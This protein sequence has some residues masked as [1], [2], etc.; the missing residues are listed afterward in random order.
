MFRRSNLSVLCF[1]LGVFGC[2]S[3]IPAA[4]Q[5]TL[6]ND[7]QW[8]G[9]TT[10]TLAFN[11][12]Q[13]PVGIAFTDTGNIMVSCLDGSVF[14]MPDVDG[15]NVAGLTPIYNLGAPGSGMTRYDDV[16]G[17]H[18]YAIAGTVWQGTIYELFPTSN[19]ITS[20]RV[21]SST[22]GGPQAL[23][24]SPFTQGHLIT[25]TNNLYDVD[26][27][28][29][30]GNVTLLANVGASEGLATDGTTL[31]HMTT[32]NYWV[33]AYTETLG[34]TV[35]YG[36]PPY[37]YDPWGWGV[38]GYGLQL[39]A[40]LL[41][42]HIFIGSRFGSLWMVD[43]STSTPTGSLVA[44]QTNRPD[45][46]PMLLAVDPNGSLLLP[47][48]GVIVRLTPPANSQKTF[49][50]VAAGSGHIADVNQGLTTTGTVGLS[51]PAPATVKV[52]LSTSTPG[53]T[54]DSSALVPAGHI[55]SSP[56]NVTTS[57]TTPVQATVTA[58]LNGYSTNITFNVHPLVPVSGSIATVN[59]G[60][61]TTGTVTLSGQ[62]PAG[63]VY[64][65]LSTTNAG[66]TLDSNGDQQVQVLVP[67][68]SNTSQPFPVNTTVASPASCTVTA[69]F[70][71]TSIP[72]NFTVNPLTL[73]GSI[74]TANASYAATCSLTLSFAP[75]NPAS[76]SLSTTTTGVVVPAAPITITAP[77]NTATCLIGTDVTTPAAATV[78][79][80]LNGVLYPINFTVNQ[81]TLT[82]SIPT[83][84]AGG[85]PVTGTLTLSFTPRHAVTVTLSGTTGIT[86]ASPLTVT[87]STKTFSVQADITTPASPQ[88]T[89]TATLNGVNYPIPF[90]VNQPALTISG[91]GTA[92]IGGVVRPSVTV[93]SSVKPS[94]DQPVTLTVSPSGLVGFPSGITIPK[95]Q[96]KSSPFTMNTNFV[97]TMTPVTVTASL[98]NVPSVVSNP[99]TIN[100]QPTTATL[101]IPTTTVIGGQTI[102]NCKATL[103]VAANGYTD[104]VF[105]NLVANPAAAISA[106][107]SAAALPIADGTKSS[108]FS[109]V[110]APVSTVTST[111]ITATPSENGYAGVG[112]TAVIK[113]KPIGISRASASGSNG[114]VTVTFFL[115]AP[116]APGDIIVGASDSLGKITF[117][118]FTVKKGW[119]YGAIIGTYT[120]SVLT[121]KI[122]VGVLTSGADT[123]PPIPWKLSN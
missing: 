66:V 42:N 29:S 70:N 9:W 91:L 117:T 113:I 39:G 81:L 95:L 48:Q 27:T 87:G 115:E 97:S 85:S 60:Y 36:F 41:A 78:T 1:L 63:G 71:N 38:N 53:V 3:S 96:S 8:S 89:V 67:A 82:G 92:M 73:T 17:P 99:V 24:P 112:G 118:P 56:F 26:P 23:V 62:A 46:E 49:L 101:T 79:A 7:P 20:P 111:T 109:I 10:S 80:T 84:S 94:V 98:T 105:A 15:Q 43:N 14:V 4:A 35:V 122:T 64:V 57:L 120:K 75:K 107:Q 55:T 103:N 68:G 40:G 69:T 34:D 28:L 21:V 31:Y 61:S 116:A 2:A 83:V 86:V 102:A 44:Y 106:F 13:S 52:L 65:Q 19:P 123:V 88:P 16:T 30:A 33:N 90:Q 32:W 45:S 58:S 119:S 93:S 18:Y 51:Q 114:M 104:P 74:T 108:T 59:A 100:L 50:S 11:F 72:V 25:D 54:M 121:T 37:T 12:P 47:F 22:I 76:I 110:T 6:V 5:I 77:A